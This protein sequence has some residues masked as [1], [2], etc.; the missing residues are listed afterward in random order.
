MQGKI[1]D[2]SSVQREACR[3]LQIVGRI[4][5]K[6]VT[7]VFSASCCIG[8]QQERPLPVR[9]TYMLILTSGVIALTPSQTILP[10]NIGSYLY[11]SMQLA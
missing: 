1:T 4:L 7:L 10:I 8:E 6:E 11:W 9:A 2:M 3:S 5:W